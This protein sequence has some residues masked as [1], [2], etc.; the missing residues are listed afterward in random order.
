LNHDSLRSSP[1]WVFC[2]DQSN[3]LSPQPTF[4]SFFASDGV[5]HVLERFIVNETMNFVLAREAGMHV[6]LVFPSMAIDVVGDASLKHSRFAGQ[7]VNVEM[8]HGKAGAS[9][10]SA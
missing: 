4:N 7:D 1:I 2:L 10:R 6:I 5:V 9:L 3:L 8:T